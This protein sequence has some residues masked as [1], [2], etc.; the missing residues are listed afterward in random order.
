[1]KLLI[2]ENDDWI[3]LTPLSYIRPVFELRCGMY[4]LL[5]RI[6]MKAKTEDVVFFVRDYLVDLV[7]K[8]Y[9]YPVNQSGELNDDLLIVDGRVLAESEFYTDKQA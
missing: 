7:R 9:Q 5:E 4:S 1:M 8:K 2:Y 3:N 6:L